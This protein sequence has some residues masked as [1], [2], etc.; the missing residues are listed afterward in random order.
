MIFIETDEQ[1]TNFDGN[2]VSMLTFNKGIG[3]LVITLKNNCQIVIDKG[4]KLELY[5]KICRER[6]VPNVG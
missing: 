1:K 6:K 5:E 3:K 4:A 2:E